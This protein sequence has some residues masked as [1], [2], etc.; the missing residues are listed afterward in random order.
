MAEG[1]VFAIGGNTITTTQIPKWMRLCSY[2]GVSIQSTITL[3]GFV[4]VSNLLKATPTHPLALQL[5]E[6]SRLWEFV[7]MAAECAYSPRYDAFTRPR[8]GTTKMTLPP[9]ARVPTSPL[10]VFR[11]PLKLPQLSATGPELT[12]CSPT[13]R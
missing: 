3:L 11:L 2:V 4:G 6:I 13:R 8:H 12:Y 7:C 5:N 1:I 10:P 9:Q